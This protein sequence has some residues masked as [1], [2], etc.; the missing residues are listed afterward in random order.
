MAEAF[1]M[2]S[3]GGREEMSLEAGKRRSKESSKEV[4]SSETD[5]KASKSIRGGCTEI[6]ITSTSRMEVV[7]IGAT[8]N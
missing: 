6:R 1:W 2:G 7:G 8:Y 3:T 4:L 5:W